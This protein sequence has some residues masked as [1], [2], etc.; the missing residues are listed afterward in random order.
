[1][2][3]R[4]CKLN[5]D[6]LESR[7]NPSGDLSA[8]VYGSTIYVSEAA[9]HVGEASQLTITQLSNGKIRLDG[10]N[11]TS[12]AANKINGAAYIDLTPPVGGFSLSATLGGGNDHVYIRP[13]TH[14][15]GVG[16][17]TSGPG[18]DVDTVD[19][20]GLIALNGVNVN[21]GGGVDNIFVQNSHI[22]SGQIG[23]LNINSGAGSDYV[24]VG[25]T[26]NY[27]SVARTI[28]IVTWNDV[29]ENDIDTVVAELNTSIYLF[30]KTGAGNDTVT[31]LANT[32]AASTFI[33]TADGNDSVNMRDGWSGRD[34]IVYL[35]A[36]N[37]TMT[38]QHNQSVYLIVDGGAG[39]DT[40]NR[41][42]DAPVTYLTITGF[43]PTTHVAF[44]N[45]MVQ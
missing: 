43:E 36:G 41:S 39:T 42:Y 28:N 44:N 13:N 12:Q 4:K 2:L 5:L 6:R 31:G 16:I 34:F 25:N 17:D 24:Q 32:T 35:G 30:V 22:G 20:N 23:D 21:T 11:N 3:T 18:A 10:G 27:Q 38:M 33:D 37:D 8:V 40:L 7:E 15:N 45:G 19:I 1:M 9:G 26:T 29:N 14:L